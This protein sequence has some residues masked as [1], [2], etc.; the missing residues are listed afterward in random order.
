MCIQL[1]FCFPF[2]QYLEENMKAVDVKLTS[3]EIAE[4]RDIAI[5]ADQLPGDRYTPVYMAALFVDSP[6]LKE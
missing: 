5:Q 1:T 2:L 6:E 3:D 4:L